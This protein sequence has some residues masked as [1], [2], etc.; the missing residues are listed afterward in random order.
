MATAKMKSL[1]CSNMKIAI[2]RGDEPLMRWNKNLVGGAYCR[3]I[4]SSG[5]LNESVE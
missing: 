5:V 1:W 4:F 3:R 2:E